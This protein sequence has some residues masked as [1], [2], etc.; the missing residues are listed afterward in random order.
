MKD[1][2]LAFYERELSWFKQASSHFAELYPK[3]ASHLKVSSDVVED[4]HVSRLIE[5]VALL[6][7]RVQ[8]RIDEDFP[9]I[10]EALLEHLYPHYLAPIPSLF[11]AE[12]VA[13][14]GL[15]EVVRVP[16]GTGVE[17]DP[18]EGLP[19]RFR[20]IYPVDLTPYSVSQ[21]KLI[22][23]PFSTP[24]PV[25]LA[26]AVSMLE[27]ELHCTNTDFS[28][29]HADKDYLDFHLRPAQPAVWRLYE[30]LN[31]HC[32]A[33]VVSQGDSDPAPVLLSAQAIEQIAFD[34][35]YPLLEY[36][37]QSETAYRYLTELF[38][39]PEK[40]LFLR[41][42]GLAQ[43]T[44]GKSG[45]LTLK[46]YFSDTDREL[47]RSLTSKH[48]S[49]SA[50]PV[51]N[52]FSQ[53][54]EPVSPNAADIE[55]L[56]VPDARYYKAFEVHSITQVK[57]INDATGEI[58]EILPFHG[59]NHAGSTNEIFWHGRRRSGLTASPDD[60]GYDYFISLSHR[61][62]QHL[63][64]QGFT[65]STHTLCSN[66]NLPVKLPYGGGQPRLYPRDPVNNLTEIKALTPPTQ[67]RRLDLGHGALW[68][69]LA[70][71]NLNL[72]SLTGHRAAVEPLKEIL[73]LYDYGNTALNRALVNAIEQVE[74]APCTV[75]MRHG[76]RSLMCQGV[77]IDILF[78][79]SQL[80]GFSL[81]LFGE[82]LNRFLASYVGINSFV[83]VSARIKG[84]DG[85]FKHWPPQT[86][87]KA[88]L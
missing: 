85:I 84:K 5:S 45:S 24:F 55:H 76:H 52:L 77:S 87:L 65:L 61:N 60:E 53:V 62:G 68:R 16:Q 36:A 20:T 17:S 25:E 57:R 35:D 28:L 40:F 66:R 46:F 9:A 73:T 69:L 11:I 10:T 7:A 2:L 41:L 3:I 80:A 13:A 43:A 32:L 44:Q 86:G 75:P 29:A 56:V 14:E 22:P 47:E 79:E 67:P 31:L 82:V 72:I 19:C 58:Q 26:S 33:V 21:A 23:R 78:N 71:L 50:T 49:L 83:Q 54:A 37:P 64:E 4:P 88:V 39:F 59:L 42:H 38:A 15:D 51:V 48:F 30:L 74:V 6:N 8:A 18:V 70:H 34:R 12:M 63:D 27:I 81:L 1:D